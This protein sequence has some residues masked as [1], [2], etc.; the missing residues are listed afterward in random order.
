MPAVVG[1]GLLANQAY[2]NEQEL[3]HR[4]IEE[5]ARGLNLLI[6]RALDTR[7]A[8]GRAIASSAAVRDADFREFQREAG[9]VAQA[10]ESAVGLIDGNGRWMTASGQ[11]GDAL[12]WPGQGGAP[13]LAQGEIEAFLAMR[14]DDGS[15]VVAV[16][17][18][19]PGVAEQRFNVA[20][21]F[22]VATIQAVVEAQRPFG[23]G[24]LV[25]VMDGRRRVVARSVNPERW[26]GQS[27]T[28]ELNQR[29]IDDISGFGTSVTLD[30][31]SSSSYLSD[32]N[33]YGW[34]VVIAVPQAN[35]ARSAQK[36]T[37][38]I[39][40]AS[41]VL[42]LIGLAV[43]FH[44]A[45]RIGSAVHALH[46]AARELGEDQVPPQFQTGVREADEVGLALHRAGVVIHESTRQ[47]EARVSEA[48][49]EAKDAQLRL[50]DSQ[51]HE[52]IGRLTGGLAHD[53]NNLLQAINSALEIL[54]HRSVDDTD[55]SVVQAALRATVRATDLVRQ[56][57]AFGRTE[58]LRA[59]AVDLGALVRSSQ[60]LTTKAVGERV[61]LAVDVE[62]D[63]PAAEVDP[64]QLELAV[65]N[66]L[67]N[68]RDA[69]AEAGGRIVVTV[70]RAGVADFAA[71]GP[72]GD[73]LCLDVADDGPGMEAEV[74]SRAFDPYYTTKPKGR[75]SG[76][77]LAQVLAFARQSGGDAWISSE[78]G[79][80]SRVTLMLP[81]MAATG[82]AAARSRATS[83]TGT[84]D[85]GG[86]RLHVLMV[87]DDP[88]VSGV[89]VPALEQAGHRV[90]H[91]E[92]ADA[93]QALLATSRR[94]DVLCT[95]IVMPGRLNGL[96]LAP[97]CRRERPR[98][99]VVVAT[100]YSSRQAPV[101]MVVLNKPY[102]FDVLI[103]T[104]HDAIKRADRGSPVSD[105]A[106]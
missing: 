68:A 104:L 63:L 51:K 101:N 106:V 74:R 84:I 15:P 56:M 23:E 20:V 33:R 54:E 80:G 27:P 36:L 65:L 67:F 31:V 85:E 105:P 49:Q 60:L 21:T 75:G 28:G 90:T 102:S 9:R 96:D 8:V 24:L 26:V 93:A 99:P 25:G 57:L 81:V 43:A 17:A 88:L 73:F 3:G 2:R 59:E 79:Q 30:G 4:R 11:I 64:T 35:L 83:R 77:G 48:V 22:P 47:L 53:F 39:V 55:R 34:R 1:F 44:N 70:R 62:P 91:C 40:T 19:E 95:D 86:D 13:T 58:P 16:F 103:E 41:A 46:G 61:H 87:E 69:L 38:Q 89:V 45:Q 42:L 78:P 98:L 29:V 12:E 37:F 66:L 7:A 50:L 14:R 52:A 6:E 76:L 97:W 5:L 92:T 100:G 82:L 71:H 94:F 18:P 10:S 72:K 32:N